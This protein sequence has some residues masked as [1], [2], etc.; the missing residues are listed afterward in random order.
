MAKKN[1]KNI[2]IFNQY[3]IKQFISLILGILVL[4]TGVGLLIT[5]YVGEY[6]P[7]RSYQFKQ[8]SAALTAFNNFTHTS[9]GFI[10]W[11]IICLLLGAIIITLVLSLSSKLE[12]KEKDRK[13]RREL[14]L[15][16][17][18]QEDKEADLVEAV[19]STIDKENK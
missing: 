17:L 9:L 5:Y 3:S 2:L 14:R 19:I 18:K 10:G 8:F 1:Q 15:Q 12:D 11:G 6:L 13:A 4:L 7:I 16:A